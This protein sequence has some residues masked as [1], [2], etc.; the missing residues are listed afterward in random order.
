MGDAICDLN[1]NLINNLSDVEFVHLKCGNMS[2]NDDD[3]F[4]L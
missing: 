3:Q 1:M 2:K 4:T